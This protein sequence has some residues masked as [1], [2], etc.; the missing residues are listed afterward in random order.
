MGEGVGDTKARTLFEAYTHW[1]LANQE[2]EL[3]PEAIF[4]RRMED[5]DLRKKRT[6]AGNVYEDVVIKQPT[7][8]S[9]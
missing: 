9:F 8:T 5:R 3:I 2:D 1:H 7:T 4:S 6:K